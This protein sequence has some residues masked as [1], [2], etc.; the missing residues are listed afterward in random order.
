L[1]YDVVIILVLPW[2]P[3][4]KLQ[5]PFRRKLS[6]CA[7]FL[8]GGFVVAAGIVRFVY[9]VKALPNLSSSDFDYTC[10]PLDNELAM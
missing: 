3:V 7:I 9:V 5:M 2:Y 8:L 6:V 10:K 1:T 4:W